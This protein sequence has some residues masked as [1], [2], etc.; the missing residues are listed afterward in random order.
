MARRKKSYL[1]AS[2]KGKAGEVFVNNF[3]VNLSNKKKKKAVAGEKATA[4]VARKRASEEK[5]RVNERVKLEKKQERENKKKLKE[6]ERY[7]K[8]MARARLACEKFDIDEICC[9][10]IVQEAQDAECTIAQVSS[11]IVKGRQEYWHEKAVELREDKYLFTLFSYCEKTIQEGLV[12]ERFSDQLF[13]DMAT[14]RP[15]VSELDTCASVGTFI[16]KSTHMRHDVEKRLNNHINTTG[17][18]H[19]K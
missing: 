12:L 1:T 9:T 18:Y 3:L 19:E 10:T 8:Y 13:T 5:K 14:A 16:E 17:L 2:N 15:E 7:A 11:M 6:Q 4:L